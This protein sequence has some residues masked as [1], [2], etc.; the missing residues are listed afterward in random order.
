MHQPGR[1][2]QVLLGDA[3]TG[4]RPYDNQPVAARTPNEV[5]TVSAT[6]V[7]GQREARGD[8]SVTV[9]NDTLLELS[10]GSS[11]GPSCPRL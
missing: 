1:V 3:A 8:I 6:S 2:V 9:V 11:S 7:N 10:L 5:R 4:A